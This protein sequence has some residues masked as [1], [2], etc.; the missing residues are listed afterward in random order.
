MAPDAKTGFGAAKTRRVLRPGAESLH[1]G[2][3]FGSRFPG[4][5]RR[6]ART[7]KLLDKWDTIL[8]NA[9]QW[10]PQRGLEA[11]DLDAEVERLYTDQVAPQQGALRVGQPGSRVQMR[12]Y[13][14]QVWRA[15]GVWTRVD[16]NVRVERFTFPGDPMRTFVQTLSVSRAPGEV[17]SLACTAAHIRGHVESSAFTAVTDVHLVADNERHKFVQETLREG[18]IEAVPLDASAVWVAKIKPAI[19]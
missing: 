4:D 19:Q 2:L 17:R 7:L 9:L 8:S 6:M 5:P 14:N 18:G 1:P 13:C 15:A 16:K 12:S 10:G 11:A 3:Q